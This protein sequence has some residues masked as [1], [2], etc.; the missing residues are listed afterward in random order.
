MLRR[1]F[2]TGA[3]VLLMTSSR[4]CWSKTAMSVDCHAHV[5]LRNAAM[6][7]DRRYTPNYDATISDYVAMLD[8]TGS[9]HGL[10]IQP[11][12]LGTNNDYLVNALRQHPTRLRG[13]AVVEPDI[14]DHDLKRLHER[15]IVG[16]R[17]NLIGKD[18]PDFN[19]E[20]WQRLL[21]RMST[22]HWH[23]ELHAEAGRLPQVVPPLLSAGLQVV[24][25]HFGR[26]D[27]EM[28]IDDPGFR[29]L[30][31]LG[32]RGRVVVKLSAPYRLGRGPRGEAIAA[33]AAA[34]LLDAYGA[35]HLVWGSDWPHTQFETAV[36]VDRGRSNLARWIPDTVVRETILST[37]PTA[38][39]HFVAR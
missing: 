38:L 13:V 8:N 7:A 20:E 30:L 17:L 1:E 36:G 27:E 4:R 28:G 9:T 26:P 37:T 5:F 22:L 21:R 15:G 10:L 34:L 18:V 33:E 6:V 39:F 16:A 14:G 2:F 19:A 29:Y 23:V 3:A 25:D 35:G 11:S 12:F 31:S 24:V 32:P